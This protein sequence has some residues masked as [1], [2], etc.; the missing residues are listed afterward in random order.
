LDDQAASVLKY[1]GV[2]AKSSLPS[3][4]ESIQPLSRQ[5][6]V[7][8]WYFE[9]N[10]NSRKTSP[11]NRLVGESRAMMSLR[12]RT[13]RYAETEE[14]VLIFGETGTGKELIARLLHDLS[15]RRKAPFVAINCAALPGPLAE[16]ELFGSTRGAYTGAVQCR[17]GLLSRASGGTLFL[18]E[19]G[20]LAPEV[21][22]KLLRALELGV[23]R[24]VGANR[25]EHADVRIVAAT[26]R[27]LE[28]SVLQGEFRA[29]LY[30]RINVLQIFAP[31]L[32]KHRGDIPQIAG[33]ILGEL[34]PEGSKI[35]VTES[36]MA[37][38]LHAAWPGNVRELKNI[39]RRSLV[40]SGGRGVIEHLES[41]P[42]SCE[43]NLLAARVQCATT[44]R[45]IGALTRNKGHLE[46]VAQ[47]LDVSV[48]TIQRRMKA[49]GLRL[50]DFRSI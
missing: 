30:Y 34:L 27:D 39:L 25:E 21:Q 43:R 22:S 32:R 16:S 37:E 35:R 47:E 15:P 19:F 5:T 10:H 49:S 24:P 1:A 20:E 46:A 40:M 4:Y 2:E 41:D 14:T 8:D 9:S 26:N 44:G 36:V 31:P 13:T 11:I 18:D 42:H 38:L 29:D 50:R 45:L 3:H 33:V 23:Y 28:K 7:G 12:A 6:L 48:R 17:S